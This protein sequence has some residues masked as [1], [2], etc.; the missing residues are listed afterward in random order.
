ME[1]GDREE[2]IGRKNGREKSGGK[3]GKRGK[4]RVE[5]R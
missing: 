3:E 4:R 2:E 1:G 5:D